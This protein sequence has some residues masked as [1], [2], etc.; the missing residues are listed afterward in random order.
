MNLYLKD[1]DEQ[2]A[3]E[4]EQ[5]PRKAKFESLAYKTVY[6]FRHLGQQFCKTEGSE[7]Y[8]AEHE[9]EP[10]EVTI[11]HGL[12]E[13]FC[14][15]NIVKYALRFKVTKNLN[16]LKK[17]ADYAHILCGV[18]IHLNKTSKGASNDVKEQQ[19]NV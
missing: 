11:Q 1:S 8:K 3:Y 2:L 10:I 15:G 4:Q 6:Y 16:D 9:I 14:L 5:K 18:K 7:H 19:K 17:V 12:A 13:G